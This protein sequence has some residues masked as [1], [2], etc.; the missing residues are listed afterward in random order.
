MATGA[1]KTF[2]AATFVY[3]LLEHAK[4]KRILFLVDTKN[5]GEQAEQEFMAFVPNESNRKFTEFYNV[6]RLTSSYIATDSQV[7]ISTIQRMYAILKGEELDEGAEDANPN[8]STWME[9]Q[10]NK[11]QAVPVEYSSKVPIEQFDFIVIDECHRSIYNLWKQVLDYFD[12]FLIGLTA[13]PDKRTFGFFEENVVSEYTYEESVLDGVNVPYDVY[14]IETEISKKGSVIKAGWFVDRRDKLTR[15]KRWQQEDEDTEYKRNDLDKKVVNPSQI[16]NIIREYK[17]ALKTTIFPDRF[18]DTGEFEVPKTLVFAKTD[19][20]ADDIIQV[21][22]EEFDE[23]NDFCKKVTYKIEEDPKS[24]LNRFRNSWAPRIA[25]TVDMIATG[26]DVKPLEVLLFMRDVKSINYFEQMKGRGTRTINFDDLKLVTKTAKHNK[27]HFVIMDAVGATKSKK[28][29]SRPLERKRGVPMKDLLNAIAFGAKDEDLFSS[30]ANRLIRLEK[31]LTESEKETFRQKANGKSIHQVVSGLLNSYHP[32]TEDKIAFKVKD[33]N[34]GAPPLEIDKTINQKMEEIRN[35]AASVFTGELN[36][37]V[38]NVRKQHDQI[39]DTMNTDRVIRAEWDTY[40]TD[41]AKE[42][43]ESF[44]QYIKDNKDEITALSLF[45][46][47]PYKRREL[48]Y[49]MVKEVLE[50][51]K[52]EK[53]LL[54]PNYVWEA[55]EQ[56][57]DVNGKNPKNEL[58]ALVSLIRKVTKLDEQLTPYNKIVDANFKKW[59]FDQNAGQHN[60]FTDEQMEW[61]RM[62]KEHIATSFHV[63]EDDFEFDPFNKYGGI[64]KFYQLFKD[65]YKKVLEELNEVL[66][67]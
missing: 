39:I 64:G 43:I 48:T 19:S 37:Y 36:D 47:Q 22:R 40:S 26:T 42:V 16:R 55:Y 3:R 49:K 57:E 25:V 29:D 11:K 62:L 18:D 27:T 44:E 66:V 21:I 14:N 10:Q 60:K 35:E 46:G 6:Q 20:H 54:S 7:C 65:D 2:T 5:L 52:L 59:V 51:L 13:T 4:A 58:V 9:Q 38:E 56:L 30:L 24:V 41:K 12:A 15:K 45:Y 53:P 33:E 32:D 23:G 28:T 61:L 50:K 63:D 1:G 34:K 8:E 67:A 17:K 31:Q